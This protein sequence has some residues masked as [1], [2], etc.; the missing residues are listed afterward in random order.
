MSMSDFLAWFADDFQTLLE[1][2]TIPGLDGPSWDRIAAY[3]LW[4]ATNNGKDIQMA[5]KPGRKPSQNAVAGAISS[6]LKFLVVG[7]KDSGNEQATHTWFQ[8]G[9]GVSFNGIIAAGI[10]IAGLDFDAYL[11]TKL[12]TDALSHVG[13]ELDLTM[14]PTGALHVKSGTFDAIVPAGNLAGALQTPPDEGQWPID[15]KFTKAM[16]IAGRFVSD[17]AENFAQA[18]IVT[19]PGPDGNSTT[20]VATSG[21]AVIEALHGSNMPPGLVMPKALATALQKVDAKPVK[22]GYSPT[23]GTL[24][25]W[26]DNDG[27]IRAQLYREQYP[28]S[29]LGAV[30]TL[31]TY[32][33][34]IKVPSGL[35]DAIS[36]VAPFG[37]DK[38]I[39][40][41][42]SGSVKAGPGR[43]ADGSL[44]WAAQLDVKDVPDGLSIPAKPLLAVLDETMTIW[45]GDTADEPQRVVVTGAG[46]RAAIS[47]LRPELDAPAAKPGPWSQ[48]ATQAAQEAPPAPAA[49]PWQPNTPSAV[50]P[51]PQAQPATLPFTPRERQTSMV[52]APGWD[53]WPYTLQPGESLAL[54]TDPANFEPMKKHGLLGQQVPAMEL[55]KA[56]FASPPAGAP[57]TGD[58]ASPWNSIPPAPASDAAPWLTSAA[59]SPS[60]AAA[61]TPAAPSVV[62]HVA[63]EQAPWMQNLMTAPPPAPAQGFQ[64]APAPA[65]AGW[66]APVS[67]DDDE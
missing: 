16:E 50:Q 11:H 40:H 26:F 12:L 31:M 39:V 13:K 34:A 35:S 54:F 21:H 37:G 18:A 56:P 59:P 55:V 36:A 2:T 46:W 15:E 10:P 29:I 28:A 19:R 20:L 64:P 9:W 27:F 8:G 52:G 25:I 3:L 38:Q 53:D 43:G 22:F 1:T 60:N 30:D 5:R 48:A 41:F 49:L 14:L 62:G 24:T 65:P 63:K 6:A 44:V 67:F 23:N 58:P 32:P 47:A 42:L 61:A 17:T 66:G 7:Y 33:N 57:P 51:P 4:Q 45:F